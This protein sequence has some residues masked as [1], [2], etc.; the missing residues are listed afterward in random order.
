LEEGGSHPVGFVYPGGDDEYP[1]AGEL[2][3]LLIKDG[4]VECMTCHAPHGADSGGANGGDG[5]GMLLRDVNDETLCQTCHT[6]HVIHNVCG[7][8]RPTCREC[9]DVHDVDNE[10]LVLIAREIDGAPVTFSE[11]DPACGSGRDYIH[12]V[13]DPPGYDGICEVCHTD[14][15]QH[16]NSAEGDH[17]HNAQMQ[18][19]AC[20]WHE[21]GFYPL[22]IACTVCHAT[23]PDATASPNRAGSHAAHF[24]AVSGPGLDDCYVCH[25]PLD[26]VTHENEAVSFASG[27]DANLDGNIDL[28]E[29]DV[30]DTCHSPSGPFDGVNDSVIGAKANWMDSVYEGDALRPDRSDW[31]LGCHDTP[32]AIVNGIT[33]PLVAGDN[34]LWGYAVNG[35]GRDDILCTDCHDPRLSHTD[36]VAKTFSLRFPLSP[37]GTP[38]PPEDPER[39]LDREGYNNGYRL[40]RID[41]GQAL[42]VPRDAGDYTAD[43]FRLCFS[44]HD[45]IKILGMPANYGSLSAP[46]AHLQLP[47]G[48]AQTNYRNEYEWGFGW[49]YYAG[50]P[51]N[52]HWNHTAV[53]NA[54]WDI[55]HDNAMRDSRHSC[56][57]CHNPHDVRNANGEST[58]AR[59]MADLAISF[60]LYNDDAVDRE[61]GYIG[62]GNYREPGGDLHC[63][64]CHV[65]FGPGNDP[66][67]TGL[68]T[69]YYRE[70]L[71]VKEVGLDDGSRGSESTTTPLGRAKATTQAGAGDKATER[72]SG[73]IR[74]E[75]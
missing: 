32:G 46:P 71:D 19:T 53:S 56:V 10:N 55:D 5:D 60:G 15:D 11:E 51:A 13:C 42:A 44:C 33:A 43:D 48:V 64:S 29:T 2:A 9:H 72:D 57:T 26:G 58:P 69:R 45:E 20:H 6:E 39:E 49:I 18:C 36:G 3:S 40:R 59:T 37:G 22:G 70:W 63:Q 31:C 73:R 47:E 34:I 66:P 74:E 4:M 67:I 68:H 61:Y 54:D 24:T 27:T 14:T 65:W 1:P 7:E 25:A 75:R 52:V 8:W 41:G 17:T 38:R 16:R 12:S 28:A 30:C 35:H 62:S 50:K 23:P 21:N